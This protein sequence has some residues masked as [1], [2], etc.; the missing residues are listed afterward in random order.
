MSVVIKESKKGLEKQ[1]RVFNIKCIIRYSSN[2][3]KRYNYFNPS[4]N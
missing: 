2:I 4:Y 3:Y 1:A